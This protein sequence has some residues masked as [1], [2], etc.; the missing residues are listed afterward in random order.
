MDRQGDHYSSRHRRREQE[1]P[2]FRSS[3]S[4]SINPNFCFQNQ[5]NFY[6]QNSPFTPHNFLHQQNPNFHSNFQFQNP[7]FSPQNPSFHGQQFPGS[8][9]RPHTPS[10]NRDNLIDKVDFAVKKAHGDVLKTGENISAWT[11]AQSTLVM[12]Q[13]DSWS[14]LG[15]QMQQVPSLKSLLIIEGKINAFIHCFVGARRITSLYDLE[16]EICKNEGIEQFEDLGLGPLLRHPLAQHYFSVNSDMTEVFKITTEEII[17]LLAEFT[18]FRKEI[19][20]EQFMDFIAEKRSVAG[21]EKLGIRIQSLGHHITFIRKARNLENNTLYALRKA[22]KLG[23][24]KPEKQQEPSILDEKSKKRPLFTSLKKELDERFGSIS[25]RVESF[26]S[27]HKGF[28]GKHIRFGSSSSENDGSDDCIYEDDSEYVTESHDDF[29]SKSVKSSDRVSS[30]P[31]PSATEEM[32]RLGMKGEIKAQVSPASSSHKRTKS[33][34]ARRK[35]K[36]RD[37]RCTNTAPSKLRKIDNVRRDALPIKNGNGADEE[38]NM[39]EDDSINEDDFSVNEETLRIFVT[40]MK[41]RCCGV[42]VGQAIKRLIRYYRVRVRKNMRAMFSSYPFIGILNVAVSSVNLGMWDSVYDTVQAISPYDSF[43]PLLNDDSEYKSIDVEPSKDAPVIKEQMGKHDHGVSVEDIIRRVAEYLQLDHEDNNEKPILEKRFSILRNLSSCECWLAEQYRVKEFRSLGNGDFLQFLEKYASLLPQELCKFL[44]SDTR[45]KFPLEVCM[46]HHQLILLVSQAS[47]NLWENK[48]ITRQDISLLLT[49][50]FP[51]MSFKVVANGSLEE[52]LSVVEKHKNNASSKSVIFSL[53]LDGTIAATESS[54]YKNDLLESTSLNDQKVKSHGSVTPKDAVAV[55]LKAPMLSDLN[56][57]SHWDLIFAP[58]FG[59]LIPWL[60]NEVKTDELLC[61]LTRDGKVIRIDP[62]ATVDSFLEAAIQGSSFQT[63]VKLL[64]LFSV[65]GGEKHAP[66]SL[67]KCHAQHAFKVILQNSLELVELRDSENNIL[68]GKVMGGERIGE[69]TNGSSDTDLHNL[70]LSKMNSAVSSLS[71]FVLDC[72]CYLPAEIRGFAADVLLSG[73]QSV[74]K[75]AASAILRE[76]SQIDQRLMLHEVGLLLGIV[77][78]IDD[79]RVFYSN[80]TA[81]L[82]LSEESSSKASRSVVNSGSKHKQ[83]VSDKFSPSE[84]RRGASVINSAEASDSRIHSGGTLHLSELNEHEDAALI[85]ESIRREEFGLDPN[86]SNAESSML[87]KQHARLGRAL[88]CLSQELYSQDSHFLLEL[89]QNADDNLYPENVEP[90]LT[91]ILQDSGITVL[92]NERGFSAQNI[93]AL[94]DVGNSTKK[95]SNAGYIGQKGIGFKSVFRITDAPEIHSNG[96]HVKFDISDGQIGFVLPTVVA[97]CNLGLFSR[98]AS[99]GSDQLDSKRWNTCIVLPFR[100][101][102]SEGTV[103]KSIMSMFLDLHPSLLLFLH[104]LQ[105]IKFRNLLE[106]SFVVM[107]KEIV[108]DGIIRVSHG[109]EKMTWLVVSQKL[110]AGFLRPDVQM[111]E[112]SMAFTLQESASGGYSPLLDQQ[113]VFAFLPLRTYGMKFIVQGDFVLPSSREEVDGDSPWNQ[114]LLSEFPDLFVNAETSFCALPCFKDYPGKAVAAYMSFVP[115]VGEVHGFFSS[116]PRLVISRLRMSNCLLLEGGKEWVPPCKVLRGWNE[117]ARYLLPDDFLHQ[118]LGLGFLDKHII[119]SDALA[120][121][122]GI[123]EYGPNILVQALSSLCH[124]ENGLKSM[125]L[126]W[127]SS[128][129]T[130]LYAMWMH[131][132]VQTVSD[133]GVEVDLINNLQK[134]SFIPLSNG[135]YGS[136]NEGTIWLHW[137]TLSSGDSVH[138]LESFP[139][140]YAKLRIVSPAL[141]SASPV[142]SSH[143]DLALDKLTSMLYKI[144]VQRLSAHEIIKVHILPAICEESPTAR[145]KKLMTEYVCF[146]MSHLHS[147]CPDCHVDK[148]RIMSELQNKAYVLTNKGFKRPAEV[149]IHFSKDF[150]NPVKIKKLI[151][152]EDLKWHEVDVSYLKHPITK[153]LASGLTKWREFFQGIGITDFVK[154]VQVEKKVSD[155][156]HALLKDVLSERDIISLGSTVK[157]WESL[158]LV[159]LL[160]LLSRSGNK[161]SCEYLLEVL[162]T[163]WDS[164]FSD[165]ATGYCTSKSLADSKTFKSSF[166]N[167]ISDVQWVVSTMDDELHY[168][169]DLYHDCDAVRSVLGASAPYAVP[170]VKS[171]KLVSDIGFKTKVMLQDVL[172]IFKVWRRCKSP[173][174]ASIAQMSKLYTFIWNEVASSKK[175]AEEL[176]SEPFIF[177]PYVPGS[178]HENVVSGVFL[179]PADVYWSDPSGATDNVKEMDSQGSSTGATAGPL[180]KTLCK[181]YPS[182]HDFFINGCGVHENPPLRSYLKTLLNLSRATLPHQSTNAVFQVFV[183]W[184][185]GLR[186]GLNAEDVVYLK[187]SLK[188]AKYTVLPTIQDKWVSLHPSFGVVCWCDD[189][190]L[191]KHFKHLDGIDFIYLGKLSKD[192]KETLKTKVSVLMKTLEI[193]ALSEVVSREAIYYGVADSSFKVSLVNWALPY[194]Q[195]YLYALHPDKYSQLKQSGNDSLNCLQVV[196]VEKLFYRNVIKGC[197]TKS[198]KRVES[199]CLLQGNILYTTQESDAHALF[200]E[201]SRLFFNGN[202]E[203]HMANFLHMLTTMAESGSNEDQTEFFI[204]NSQKVPKLPEGESVWSLNSLSSFTENDILSLSN[205]ASRNEQSAS[206]SKRKAAITSNWPPVDWKTAPGFDYGRANGFNSLTSVAPPSGGSKK[207]EKDDPQS[208]DEK[209]NITPHS[210]N[211]DWTFEDDSALVLP[212]SNNMEE[213]LSDLY[214]ET[215]PGM[216]CEFNPASFEYTPETHKMDLSNFY[217]KD[218]I[219]IG[220]PNAQGILT[221]KLGEQLAFK[222]FVERAGKE[223]VRWINEDTETGLPYDILIEDKKNGKQF[224]EVK[225]TISSR[226]NW[227]MISIR[228]WQFAVEKGE[229]FSIAH[230]V[231]LKNN[232]AKVSVYTN[233]VKLLREGK[234]QLVLVAPTQQEFSV[235]SS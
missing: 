202:P 3:S 234:M 144:G 171:G 203:L 55:L 79:H 195:R 85:I 200:M 49:R 108:G 174:M 120:R 44:T 222:Y 95:G 1:P 196:V 15:F 225:A 69:V 193:P 201:L 229:A 39:K 111:T 48:N 220:T 139:H 62:S 179:S 41:E 223:A 30:C 159:N 12:L 76:C 176:C 199:S 96:F 72:L 107:R 160:F 50:Q 56:L 181:I 116:L 61:L 131:F 9:F 53:T 19:E 207:R 74:I 205:L 88:H 210:I 22:K 158:E 57:W 208:S 70:S 197:G 212:D 2:P 80:G 209:V 89:V 92:N 91:F 140:L 118:H 148:E 109:K 168:P 84:G 191:K 164:C 165:K 232:I 18:R 60:L 86:I 5:P 129:I 40:I 90:T 103:M 13:V 169:K 29:S 37:W 186:S 167:T 45:E 94:C 128:C 97:P 98:M 14:S 157:D 151:N 67:L 101:S 130:E 184:A 206:R 178:R 36:S 231:L 161:K 83:H 216:S 21:K 28:S 146:V 46:M 6:P 132:S 52:F 17:I 81:G 143:T 226:K 115:L 172:E 215:D 112:I 65:V 102:L 43:K 145:D 227:F 75:D 113:P 211:S 16:V 119:L 63:A 180:D 124:T 137:D 7:I 93:R 125:G 163:L 150:G 214:H 11:V 106:D 78:W 135:T 104:R 10:Q 133:S 198:D 59:P 105:C 54:A 20:I 156:S 99:S 68:N 219:R 192:D 217:K 58:S 177:V 66:V 190:K 228:E 173:F 182:L 64:S 35:R 114:W 4:Q 73:M 204:L 153:S 121:A 136:L 141:L 38:S 185:E 189:K 138:G 71:R 127:L 224:I 27:L 221:G 149:S 24:A 218:Q 123:E 110:N 32:A 126:G 142:D 162:D 8:G 31:Y 175:L 170:K 147:S 188:K 194:A 77:E 230:V 155:L 122:L 213:Q 152:V 235:V 42:S 187:K 26:T 23:D 87:K 33:R 100:S 47:N 233:P 117:Q 82:F 34:A 166:I 25:E 51:F 134:I 154:V 183:K